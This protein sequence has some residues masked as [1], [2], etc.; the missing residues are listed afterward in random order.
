M[1][2]TLSY[3][4]KK[5]TKGVLR[6]RKSKTDRQRNGHKKQIYNT[7]HRKLKIEQH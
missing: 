6:F 3:L 1:I 5:D 4:L 2:E 7:L